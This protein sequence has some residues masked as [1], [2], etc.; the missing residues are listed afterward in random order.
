MKKTSLV[1]WLL[2]LAILLFFFISY[3]AFSSRTDLS[4]PAPKH[5]DE[6]IVNNSL[7]KMFPQSVIQMWKDT[8]VP[9]Q[10]KRWKAGCE[11]VNLDYRFVMFNDKELGVWIRKEYPRYLDLFERYAFPSLRFKVIN[12]ALVFMGFTWLT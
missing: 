4:E 2:F 5:E 1:A 7:T 11:A 12:L 8:N 3:I 9:A 6:M 10:L